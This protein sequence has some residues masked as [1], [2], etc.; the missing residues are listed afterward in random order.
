MTTV[1]L[2]HAEGVAQRSRLTKA[3]YQ[4]DDIEGSSELTTFEK[5]IGDQQY[6][7]SILQRQVHLPGTRYIFE[8]PFFGDSL[9]APRSIRH[10]SSYQDLGIR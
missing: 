4:E 3:R 9:L 1:I 5:E 7:T 6:R 8:I 2:T 10:S